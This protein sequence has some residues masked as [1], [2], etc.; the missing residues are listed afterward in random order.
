[1]V[2]I[3][4]AAVFLAVSFGSDPRWRD[5]RRAAVTLASILVF[6]F[7]LQFLTTYFEVLYGLAN[8]SF[9]MVLVVWLL[10]LSI[11]L[12]ALVRE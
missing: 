4:L 1:V 2:C 11:R 5:S 12:R 6:A 7:G 10:T 8:R 3:L 9:A